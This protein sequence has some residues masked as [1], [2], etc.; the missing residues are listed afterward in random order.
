MAIPPLDQARIER[1]CG[2]L[3]SLFALQRGTSRRMFVSSASR[4]RGIE[5]NYLSGRGSSC[6]LTTLLLGGHASCDV[7]IPPCGLKVELN[8]VQCVLVL[9]ARFFGTKHASIRLPVLL[10]TDQRR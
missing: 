9:N 5:L 8:S 7:C 1:R 2:L 10:C 4:D 3:L 6:V